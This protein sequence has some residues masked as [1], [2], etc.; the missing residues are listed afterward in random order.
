MTFEREKRRIGEF[1][2]GRERRFRRDG[3]SSSN[4][5][6]DGEITTK[7]EEP[8]QTNI[9]QFWA[10]LF[11][12]DRIFPS[13]M[14]KTC[15]VIQQRLEKEQRCKK[16]AQFYS[17]S[18][19]R[20]DDLEG[21]KRNTL[22]FIVFSFRRTRTKRPALELMGLGRE[23]KNS[24]MQKP[25]ARK[26]ISFAGC[27]ISNS[28]SRSLFDLHSTK[29]QVQTTRHTNLFAWLKT[30]PYLDDVSNGRIVFACCP[31]AEP[32]RQPA[33]FLPTWQ[34]MLCPACI[35]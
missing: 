12:R 5:Q 29:L 18:P 19:Y 4:A 17:H 7:P 9:T 3:F 16:N 34:I 30:L 11:V 26:F 13:R 31:S 23:K 8:L 22:N 10:A 21:M 33:I 32:L 27:C 2:D 6:E 35:T 15:N 28:S 14:M 1:F 25:E 20:G 24:E